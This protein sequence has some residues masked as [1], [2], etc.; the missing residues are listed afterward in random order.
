MITLTTLSS[1]IFP[2][3]LTFFI[4]LAL[5]SKKDIYLLLTVTILITNKYFSFSGYYSEII[6]FIVICIYLLYLIIINYN[7]KQKLYVNKN[8]AYTLQLLSMMLLSQVQIEMQLHIMLLFG[9]FMLFRQER[10]H[11]HLYIMFLMILIIFVTTGGLDFI[12]SLLMNLQ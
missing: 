6:L 4:L 8:I 2:V 7:K 9:Y 5:I 3:L 1:T 11:K 12:A 10:W